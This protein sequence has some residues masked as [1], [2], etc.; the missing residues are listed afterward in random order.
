[1]QKL[2]MT[3]LGDTVV[4]HDDVLF[5]VGDLAESAYFVQS[6]RLKHGFFVFSLEALSGYGSGCRMESKQAESERCHVSSAAIRTYYYED[7]EGNDG[8]T[9]V[10]SGHAWIAEMALWT[11]WTHLGDLVSED[12][13]R[14]VVL[15]VEQFCLLVALRLLVFP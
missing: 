2:A 13:S 10:T 5:V 12:V 9:H 14:L 15:H 6:G 11:P 4:A 3:A 8:M 1:M 7:E